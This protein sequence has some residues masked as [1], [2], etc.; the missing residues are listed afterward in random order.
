METAGLILLIAGMLLGLVAIPFG[1][2]GVVIILIS[3]LVYAI[4]TGFSAGVGVLF[5]AVLCVLTVIAETADNWLMALGARR[6]GASGASTWLS[7]LG[8]LS[9]AILIGGPAAFLLGPFGPIAGG[10]AGA[11]LIVFIYERASGK[12][13][14]EA[15]RVGWGTFLGRTAGI[16]LKLVIAITIIAAVILSILF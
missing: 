7:L 3:V 14:R 1:F 16:L 12:N 8:G 11:F 2:P 5:F 9:G 13:T 15:L 4:L 10:F 6:F